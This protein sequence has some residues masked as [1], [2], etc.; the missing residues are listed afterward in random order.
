MEYRSKSD[1]LISNSAQEQLIRLFSYETHK[2]R[3][4]FILIPQASKLLRAQ[5]LGDA[6]PFISLY[7]EVPT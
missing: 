5:A 1:L 4:I 3:R 2:R 6:N 7:L